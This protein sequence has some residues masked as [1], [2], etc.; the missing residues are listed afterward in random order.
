MIKRRELLVGL[1]AL[2]LAQVGRQQQPAAR[3]RVVPQ[4]VIDRF[5]LRPS[6]G[7]GPYVL[8][9]NGQPYDLD[10]VI[11]ILFDITKEHWATR[12]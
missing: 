5:N 1:A 12:K 9:E 7:Y 4:N 11:A 8:G 3:R 10:D 2:P 6:N